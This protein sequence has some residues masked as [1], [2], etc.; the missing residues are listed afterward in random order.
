MTYIGET[1]EGT[2]LYRYET[3][4]RNI[5][6]AAERR[7]SGSAETETGLSWPQIESIIKREKLVEPLKEIPE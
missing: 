5:F 1:K 7:V 6:Y 4:L 2:K 3:L